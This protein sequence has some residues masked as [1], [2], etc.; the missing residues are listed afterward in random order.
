MKPFK[1]LQLA[2]EIVS[3]FQDNV[4]SAL[5]PLTKNKL[6][7]GVLIENISLVASGDN[8]IAHK[9][10]RMPVLWFPVRKYQN[11]DVWEAANTA[12]NTLLTLRCSANVTI[13]LW[14]A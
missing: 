9:L 3:R 11:A 14:V 8:Q 7:D 13:S 10:G 6:I 2:D 1:K 12:T 4:E 5:D